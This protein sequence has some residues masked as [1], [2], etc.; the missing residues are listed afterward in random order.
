[1]ERE[2]L[3][4]RERDRYGEFSNFYAAPITLRGQTWP[5]TEHFFQAIKFE[6]TPYADVVREA[7]SPGEA[8]KLGRSRAHPI[9]EDW[10]QVK[11]GLM[12]EAVTAKFTQHPN[13]ARVLLDT[14]DAKLVEHTKNDRCWADGGDGTGLNWLG[15]VLMEVRAELRAG[16]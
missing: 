16:R 4:Y 7:H 6:G 12:K 8:A 15:M 5:T 2:I 1:M 11:Y 13:L 9:R 10:E 3:F 14:G